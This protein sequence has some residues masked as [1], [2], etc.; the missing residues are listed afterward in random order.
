MQSHACRRKMS[1]VL[2]AIGTVQHCQDICVFDEQIV[3]FTG[4]MIVI[5]I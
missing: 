4:G 2:G 3:F 1:P 5:G